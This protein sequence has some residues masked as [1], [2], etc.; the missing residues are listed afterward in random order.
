MDKIV[1]IQN[2]DPTTL[3]LQ[4]YSTDDQN[5]ISSFDLE[6]SF[7]SSVDYI[8][9][10]IYDVNQNLLL[11]INNFTNYSLLNNA[12]QINPEQDLN[13]YGFDEGQYI[14]NYSFLKNILGSTQNNRYYISEISSDRTE[15]RL[16]TN[17][18]SNDIVIN[19][20]NDYK[21]QLEQSQYY[22]DFYL[23]FSNNDLVIA[24]NVLLDNSTP[25][26]PTV[27]IKLYEPLPTQFDLK[28]E[29]SVVE[30][31]SDPLTYQIDITLIFNNLDNN[32][33]LNGPNF[34]IPIKYSRLLV[35]GGRLLSL[36]PHRAKYK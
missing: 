35:S 27:L 21:I 31:I 33:Q 19:Q 26:N 17:L 34:N 14:T 32:I 9:Y 22:K 16:D 36:S 29:L 12:L 2:L 3:E 28:S 18:I 20:T 1:N 11:Y 24:N 13:S 15:I 10:S 25:D 30:T 23:N 4:T 5:L 8:E 7:T 6:N